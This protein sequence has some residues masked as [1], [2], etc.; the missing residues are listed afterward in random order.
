MKT[1]EITM[2]GES[3]L[4]SSELRN[5]NRLEDIKENTSE[6]SLTIKKREL[7]ILKILNK[8]AKRTI[9]IMGAIVGMM[10]LVPLTLIIA[11]INMINKEQGPIFYSQTRIGENGKKFKIYKY[12]TMVVNADEILKKILKE[13]PE[14][15]IEW[16]KN[17][18]FQNDPRITKIGNFL[19][20]TSL[21]EFPQFIN[22][23]RG[24]M[25]LVGPRAVVPDEIEKFGEYAEYVYSVK[26]GITGYWAANGRSNTSYEERVMM[27]CQYVNKFSIWMDAKILFKTV[28]SV[29]KK[30]GAI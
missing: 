19:R 28:I 21:D 25:S 7:P 22:V 20:K 3:V 1:S 16:K 29:I 4:E 9:D 11:F 5:Y 24:N 13:N 8:A 10:F 26:P 23:L 12:R 2:S 6:L 15:R 30:E 27:E 14:M 17:R 18:K